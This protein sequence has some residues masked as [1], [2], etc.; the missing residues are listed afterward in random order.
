[1]AWLWYPWHPAIV[2]SE[3]VFVLYGGSCLVPRKKLGDSK[4][5]LHIYFIC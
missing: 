1:M 4:K 3:S 2:K 5:E